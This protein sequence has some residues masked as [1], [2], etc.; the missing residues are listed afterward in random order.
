M[1]YTECSQNQCGNPVFSRGLCRKHYEQ[2]RLETA[3]PCS[4]FGCQ[5]RS[6]RGTLCSTHYRA[7]IRSGHPTCTVAGCSQPQKT[8]KSGLCERHLFRFTR[9][10]SVEQPRA[11]D[12]GSREVHPLYQTYHWHRRR[13]GGMC[14][15]WKNDFWAFVSAVEP[16]PD[17]H[18]IRKIDPKKPLGPGNW[19][20]NEKI[21][22]KDKAAYQRAWRE[23]NPER[24]K[25]ND[26]KKMFGITLQQYQQMEAAQQGKCAICGRT[27]RTFDKHGLP[28]KMPV[29]HCHKTG[30][31]RA[32]LCTSCNRGL[33]LFKDDPE[34]LRV[35]ALYIERHLDTPTPT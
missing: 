33:G 31:V 25:N 12:W 11:A 8:L 15:E 27:E 6:Y 14:D 23:K 13:I 26:L 35:A 28:R 17:G 1:E 9:H 22:C 2:E 34:A 5:A 19:F 20:W 4:F 18:T 29:D 10:G 21:P 32:L 16:R 3:A 24:A 7:Q 30:K